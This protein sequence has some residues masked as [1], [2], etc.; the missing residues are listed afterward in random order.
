M[1]KFIFIK[2][3]ISISVFLI[4]C[5]LVF[6]Y[7]KND[8]CEYSDLQNTNTN[9]GCKATNLLNL[10]TG[11]DTNGNLIAP[12]K[13]IIDPFWKLLNNPPLLSCTNPLTSS[14]NGSA[15][16]VN[17]ASAGSSGWV[18]QPTASTLAPLDLGTT[19][20]FGCNNAIN[21]V[22]NRI[23]YVFVR[24]FCILKNTSIDF[25]FSFKGDDQIYFEL[26]N[27]NTNTVVHTSST[28]I[29][30]LPA[31]AS[32]SWNATAI[33]LSIGSYSLRAYLVNTSSVVTGFSFTG[34]L[35]TTNGDLALS[36][37][38]NGCCENN[39][40]SILNILENNCN[41]I[42]DGSDIV[43]NGFTFQLK[44]SSGT[45]IKTGITDINGNLFF[46]GLANGTYTVAIVPQ[47]GWIPNLPTGGTITVDIINN[48]ITTIQFF[49]CP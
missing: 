39:T 19:D 13:G 38:A 11:I 26:I 20:S 8:S 45:I 27:N 15:Y 16:I 28:Y 37:N 5:S 40:I 41:K 44:N 36:D 12:G 7:C 42:F 21:S 17:F 43:G 31:S 24:S 9:G 49:N 4:V 33:P 18:N 29:F 14:I 1:K 35:K 46:S 48:S 30:P 6:Q 10:S 3:T 23:P 22:G 34:N 25:N 2:K 47:P 32:T